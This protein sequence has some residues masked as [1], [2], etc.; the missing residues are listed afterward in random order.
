MVR[1]GRCPWSGAGRV[2]IVKIVEKVWGGPGGR[3]GG[4]EGGGAPGH[5]DLPKRSKLS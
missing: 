5:R 2:K 3:G 4:G 1:G